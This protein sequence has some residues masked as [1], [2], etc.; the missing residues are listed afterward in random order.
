[1]C[2]PYQ[3]DGRV[4]I[5]AILQRRWPLLV[6]CGSWVS[7]D[8]YDMTLLYDNAL[9]H[10][11]TPLARRVPARNRT[12]FSRYWPGNF[13]RHGEIPTQSRADLD[14]GC[15]GVLAY[16]SAIQYDSTVQMDLMGQLI[17]FMRCDA[18]DTMM[19]RA[20]TMSVGSNARKKK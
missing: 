8:R 2:F 1:V 20:V 18:D 16:L 10:N 19:T 11:R 15:A 5:T 7:Q 6:D 12:C 3:L 14:P 17:E 9:T 4:L 13:L